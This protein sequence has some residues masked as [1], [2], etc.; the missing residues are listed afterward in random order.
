M[1]ESILEY[2]VNADLFYRLWMVAEMQNPTPQMPMPRLSGPDY[3][4]MS[5]PR[6][7]WFPDLVNQ[8]E[9]VRLVPDAIRSSNSKHNLD[10]N[11]RFHTGNK[12]PTISSEKLE[13]I[14]GC[15]KDDV[16]NSQNPY[17]ISSKV[18]MRTNGPACVS[19][20]GLKMWHHQDTVNRRRGDA[21]ICDQAVFSWNTKRSTKSF[22]ESGPFQ[23]TIK[24]FRA[25]YNMG[26]STSASYT[27]LG[28][29]WGTENGIRLGEEKVQ[30]VI[31]KHG[32]KVNY[33]LSD[34]A[35]SDEGEEFIFWDE[36]GR[37]QEGVA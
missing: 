29:S 19:L 36:I 8:F 11:L 14:W 6:K 18:P 5:Q 12:T 25:A 20:S 13:M 33:L 4:N 28:V 9:D 16:F 22:R 17:Q 1:Y 21:I 10:S 30:D 15:S 35:F 34:S 2:I 32:I 31:N 26:V 23:V 7:E 24:D 37:E 27:H 3:S